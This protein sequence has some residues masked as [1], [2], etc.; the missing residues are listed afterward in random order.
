[1]AEPVVQK[2]RSGLLDRDFQQG[3]TNWAFRPRSCD[4]LSQQPPLA[5][6][7]TL[8]FYILRSV[9]VEGEVLETG[10]LGMVRF[11]G[12]DFPA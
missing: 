6:F 2:G 4:L 11:Q 10:R 5:S 9:V 7:I 8:V 12:R 1:M 3:K